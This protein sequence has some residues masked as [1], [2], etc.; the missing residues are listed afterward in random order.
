MSIDTCQSL[1][2]SST[3]TRLTHHALERMQTRR[4]S[5]EA[6][7]MVLA[8]GRLSYIRGAAIYVIGRREIERYRTNGT[9]LSE[10]EGL[11]VVCSPVGAVITVYR[12]SDFRGLRPGR[13]G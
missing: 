9:D 8:Y 1:E 2:F 11:L 5:E 6:I 7:H 13:R 4:V 10:F 12:N 3:E